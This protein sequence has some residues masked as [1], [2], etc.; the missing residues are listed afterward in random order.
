M[1]E[2]IA[3]FESPA[4]SNP[5]DAAVA[6]VIRFTGSEVE[7]LWVRREARPGCLLAE[8]SMPSPVDGPKTRTLGSR[9]S[10]QTARRQPSAPRPFESYSRKRAFCSLAVDRR[11]LLRFAAR[12]GKPF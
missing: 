1:S 3:G 5:V 6:V 9:Y 7:V 12:C 11:C 10:A 4:P 8:D 2:A